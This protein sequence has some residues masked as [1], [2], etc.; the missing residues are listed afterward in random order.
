MK[1]K[2]GGGSPALLNQMEGPAPGLVLKLVRQCGRDK[3]P[4]QR[5]RLGST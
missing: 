1:C 5:V 4:E 3:F 2:L